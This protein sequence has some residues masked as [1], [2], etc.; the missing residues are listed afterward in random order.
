MV[1]FSTT[2]PP[3]E[4]S[5]KRKIGQTEYR[6][7][8]F[9]RKN[10]K[11]ASIKYKFE[12]FVDIKIS[13]RNLTSVLTQKTVVLEFIILNFEKLKYSFKNND[14]T[15]LYCIMMTTENGW[16]MEKAKPKEKK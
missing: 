15:Y 3:C 9:N 5:S 10:L 14:F 7:R 11:V 1:E 6:P 13:T 8:R 4:R 16:N 2:A 12:F